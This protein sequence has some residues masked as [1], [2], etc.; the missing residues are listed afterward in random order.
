MLYYQTIQ[1]AVIIFVCVA[2][3]I[4]LALAKSAISVEKKVAFA[5]GCNTADDIRLHYF[6]AIDYTRDRRSGGIG[7]VDNSVGDNV[8]IMI[9][10][11]QSYLTAM[12]YMMAFHIECII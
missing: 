6:S 11:V 10:D 5:F 8:E 4:G 2:R 3:H 9:C 1:W 12:H 7:K